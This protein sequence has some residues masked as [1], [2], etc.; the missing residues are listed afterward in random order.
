[1]PAAQPAPRPLDYYDK[2]SAI[3]ETHR[4]LAAVPEVVHVDDSSRDSALALPR[5]LLGADSHVRI[6]A[7]SRNFRRRIAMTAGLADAG[8]NAVAVCGAYLRT[9]QR[10]PH[11]CFADARRNA[12]ASPGPARL[13][14]ACAP[15][16]IAPD[17]TG[18]GV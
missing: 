11:G 7:L 14:G 18:T 17:A 15:R 12:P 1:M 13:T 9:R 5:D 3:A 6:V 8:G 2:L 10:L 4:R 16:Y